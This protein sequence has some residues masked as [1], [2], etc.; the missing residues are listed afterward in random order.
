MDDISKNRFNT[1]WI[2]IERL[3]KHL[4]TSVT[5]II[6]TSNGFYF[7]YTITYEVNIHTSKK[8][9]F[10]KLTSSHALQTSNGFY[11]FYTITYEVNIR[12]SKK[13]IFI[14]LT[15]SHARS[16]CGEAF[17]LAKKKNHVFL[18]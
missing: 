14:K 15:S 11:F 12:T 2:M 8:N 16:A 9:I 10:I 18:F 3:P 5:F 13:N 4:G 17:F 1:N 6:Q 7:F